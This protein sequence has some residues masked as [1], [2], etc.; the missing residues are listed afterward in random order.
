MN[1]QGY[2]ITLLGKKSGVSS[3]HIIISLNPAQL[4]RQLEKSYVRAE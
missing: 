3:K 1:Q 2:N 4:N